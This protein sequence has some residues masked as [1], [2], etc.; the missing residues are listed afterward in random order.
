M[1]IK[2]VEKKQN[3]MNLVKNGS[4]KILLR[5]VHINLCIIIAIALMY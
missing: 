2:E 5:N 1:T 3:E 4:N